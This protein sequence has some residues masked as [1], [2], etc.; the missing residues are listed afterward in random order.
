M[1]K[2]T[3]HDD[4]DD[5]PPPPESMEDYLKSWGLEMYIPKFTG[6]ERISTYFYN[7]LNAKQ[8]PSLVSFREC[9]YLV[10]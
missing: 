2:E 9:S 8:M 6:K 10:G 5:A 4:D 1:E 3:F 7:I